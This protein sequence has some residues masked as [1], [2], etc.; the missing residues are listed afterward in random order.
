MSVWCSGRLR[1][2][3]QSETV[4][5]DGTAY[6]RCMQKQYVSG[7]A[8]LTWSLA[9]VAAGSLA[10]VNSFTGWAMV[11]LLAV[12]PSVLLIRLKQGPS[13]TMSESIQEAIRS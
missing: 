11:A 3:V 2:R 4:R 12:G 5:C 1:R 13:Q 9:V 8:A 10:H 6:S 7:A